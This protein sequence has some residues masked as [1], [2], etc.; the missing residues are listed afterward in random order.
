MT[1]EF[2]DSIAAAIVIIF[3]LALLMIIFYAIPSI[4][5][6]W[7]LYNKAGQPGW[8]AIIPVYSS[9]IMSKIGGMPLALG[10]AAGIVPLIG[11]FIASD[12]EW[13][14]LIRIAAIVLFIVL[15]IPFSKRYDRGPGFWILTVLL[16]IVAVFLVG[17]V[18]YIGDGA[19]PAA[20]AAPQSA[21]AATPPATP[22]TTPPAA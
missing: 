11:Y 1:N 18:K 8:A 10:L 19:T 6:W 3:L 17:K 5:T 15:L 9:V 20:V 7:K 4:I 16:P 21:A 12:N 22:P 14:S 13:Q 2:S